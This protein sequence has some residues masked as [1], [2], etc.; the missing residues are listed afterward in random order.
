[1]EKKTSME[2]RLVEPPRKISVE[3]SLFERSSKVLSLNLVKNRFIMRIG[4]YS[5][6][7]CTFTD[8]TAG[9]TDKPGKKEKKNQEQDQHSL[10][11]TE[12]AS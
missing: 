7:Q 11:R 2:F 8:R 9:E 3:N 6:F 4:S 5:Y 1:M 10:L 12:Q